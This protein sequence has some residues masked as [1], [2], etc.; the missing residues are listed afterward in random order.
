MGRAIALELAR[1]G[2]DVAVCD[3]TPRSTTETTQLEAWRGLES[4]VEE[5]EDLGQRS[6]SLIGDV[7]IEADVNHM[8]AAA[9]E[10]LGR[11]DIVVNN[12]AARQEPEVDGSWELSTEDWNQQL[13]INLTGPFLVCK[14]A[15]PHL[16]GGEGD[17]RIINIASLAG[18]IPLRLRPGYTASK[19]GLIGLTRVL[20]TEL[21]SHGITV[22][23]ICPG[24]ID[25]DRATAAQGIG[26]SKSHW[27]HVAH[28]IVP[29]ARTGSAEEVAHV[30]AFLASRSSSYINGQAINVDG[31]WNMA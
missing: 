9:A 13:A 29:A 4:V 23:A 2:I 27:D 7:S 5:I 15:I 19:H 16:L 20:A 3:V 26:N 6:V 24:V 14:A 18:R 17:R 28:T 1:A 25:T 22:N 31:G 10:S 12:A 30:A 8:V 11:I 21:A